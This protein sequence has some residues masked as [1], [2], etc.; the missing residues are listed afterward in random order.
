MQAA[1]SIQAGERTR[2]SQAVLDMVKPWLTGDDKRDAMYLSRA[3]RMIGFSM[4]EWRQLVLEAA[5]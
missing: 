2:F 1:K 4:R 5:K 3:F